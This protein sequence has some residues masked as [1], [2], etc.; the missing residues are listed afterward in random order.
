M[1]MFAKCLLHRSKCRGGFRISG[2]EV[3]I[4]KGVGF[5]LLILSYLP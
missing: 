4:Y 5:A 1:S 2:K 3:H